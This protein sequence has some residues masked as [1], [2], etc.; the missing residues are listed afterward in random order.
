MEYTNTDIISE[1]LTDELE[2]SSALNNDNSFSTHGLSTA[3]ET[4]PPKAGSEVVSTRPRHTS[5]PE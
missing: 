3:N 1:V 5:E 4:V 2:T